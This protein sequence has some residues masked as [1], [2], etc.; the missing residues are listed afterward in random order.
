SLASVTGRVGGSWDRFLAYVKAGGMPRRDDRIR[1]NAQAAAAQR[2][3]PGDGKPPGHSTR[4]LLGAQLSASLRESLIEQMAAITPP[5]EAAAWARRNLPAKNTLTAA[6]AK[7]VEEQFQARLSTIG[8][9]WIT[10]EMSDGPAP[11]GSPDGLAPNDPLRADP[12][13]AGMS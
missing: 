10:D 5:D 1:P 12:D 2:S 6:D 9:A 13:G 3:A 7:I 8:D 4:S 11:G